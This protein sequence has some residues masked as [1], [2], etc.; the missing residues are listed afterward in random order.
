MLP[1][2]QEKQQLLGK[3]PFSSVASHRVSIEQIKFH[4]HCSNK[5]IKFADTFYE[6][7]KTKLLRLESQAK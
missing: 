3:T 5:S 6:C 4:V 7:Y 1:S 2:K